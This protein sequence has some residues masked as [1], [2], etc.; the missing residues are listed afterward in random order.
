MN[1][2]ITTYCKVNDDACYL[3]GKIWFK[4]DDQNIKLSKAMYK[5]LE[6]QYPKFYKMDILSKYGF[7]T[8]EVLLAHNETLKKYNDDEVAMLFANTNSSSLTDKKY[9]ETINNEE[10]QPSPSLFVYTLPNILLGEIA[11]RNKWYGENMFFVLPNFD[12]AFITQYAKVLLTNNNTKACLIA[13][14]DIKEN[15]NDVFLLSIE[16][17]NGNLAD[18][19]INFNLENLEKLYK[20]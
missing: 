14:V 15:K 4:N 3:N 2:K 10:P 1:L 19:A 18:N 8:S 16:K 13:W 11:I 12:T 20:S 6:I 7:V 17:D 5:A 9:K